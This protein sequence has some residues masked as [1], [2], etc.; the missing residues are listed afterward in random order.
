MVLQSSFLIFKSFFLSC[1]IPLFLTA[2]ELV[3]N[4]LSYLPV[5]GTPSGL[6]LCFL[7]NLWLS[8]TLSP[9]PQNTVSLLPSP[10]FLSFPFLLTLPSPLLS[11]SLFFLS[12]TQRQRCLLMWG[13]ALGQC[14]MECPKKI[15]LWLC[16]RLDSH[17]SQSGCD[18]LER[19]TVK[20]YIRLL[21]YNSAWNKSEPYL[22]LWVTGRP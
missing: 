9:L 2:E 16:S 20:L 17:T 4:D 5:V 19:P 10:P 22:M 13:H 1:F 12:A 14:F 3:N 21:I 15:C 7:V 6:A 11:F 8:Q 18:S